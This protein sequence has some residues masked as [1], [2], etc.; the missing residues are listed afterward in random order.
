MDAAVETL[1]AYWRLGGFEPPVLH[2]LADWLNDAG[3]PADAIAVLNDR[4][5][6][7]AAG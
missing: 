3:R 4:A 5:V 2:R 6:R 1:E 7:R